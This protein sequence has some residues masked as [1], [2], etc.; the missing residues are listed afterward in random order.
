M[1]QVD[2]LDMSYEDNLKEMVFS[3]KRDCGSMI[4]LK[5]CHSDEVNL[6][7]FFIVSRRRMMGSHISVRYKIKHYRLRVI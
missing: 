5:D 6:D 7:I 2:F 4:F 3:P 1:I